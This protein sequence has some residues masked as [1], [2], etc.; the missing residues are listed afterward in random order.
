M[1]NSLQIK[2][3]SKTSIS[4][5]TFWEFLVFDH[6]QV[7]FCWKMA[8]FWTGTDFCYFFVCGAE[9]SISGQYRG[10]SKKLAKISYFHKSGFESS[11]EE[12]ISFSNIWLV[13]GKIRVEIFII[14]HFM[15]SHFSKVCWNQ[16]FALN[17]IVNHWYVLKL[18]G[19]ENSSSLKL[20]FSKF[21]SDL[22]SDKVGNCS[23]E[24]R[25]SAPIDRTF[26]VCSRKK[27]I[28]YCKKV[29]IRHHK[30]WNNS[31]MRGLRTKW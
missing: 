15:K 25:F 18:Q 5:Y 21:C 26:L 28:L 31:E 29:V 12:K 11:I 23:P 10:S 16:T 17:K 22:K 19:R 9:W 8:E 1:T 14:S 7:G 3:N 4:L 20:D 24:F 6:H 30:S 2:N 27:L 13:F